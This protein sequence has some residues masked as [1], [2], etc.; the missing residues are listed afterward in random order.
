MASLGSTLFK[1]TWKER[2]TPLQRPISA[3]RASVR[4]TSGNA[5]TSWPTVSA[6]DFKGGYTGGRIRNGKFS[7]DQLDVTA[8]LASWITPSATDC[9][10]AGQKT[11][12]MSGASLVQQTRLTSWPTPKAS[13][14]GTDFAIAKR[15]KSGG[16]SLQTAS[17]LAGWPTPTTTDANRKPSLMATP[18]NLTLNHAAA[19]ANWSTEN[20]PARLTASGEML[21]GCSAGMNV[22]GQ[23]NPEHS[24]WLQGLP[25]AWSEAAPN[26]KDW[27]FVQQELIGAAL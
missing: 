7:T 20:G 2:T 16:L 25:K 3:L 22:G 17:Q 10:R 8:Q 9:R 4:R 18:Q 6:T 5:H 26:R 13:L 12:N 21:T 24:R 1:L 19:L 27:Q 15:M 14:G 11:A 23:L